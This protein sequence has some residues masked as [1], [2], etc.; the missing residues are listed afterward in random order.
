MG[1]ADTKQKRV[2][3]GQWVNWGEDRVAAEGVFR[4]SQGCWGECLFLKGKM[5]LFGSNM[6][7]G[8]CGR[9]RQISRLCIFLFLPTPRPSKTV[10]SFNFSK[11]QDIKLC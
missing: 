11:S 7:K 10:A 8:R 3:V 6:H 1:V 9:K 5:T 2:G 4:V